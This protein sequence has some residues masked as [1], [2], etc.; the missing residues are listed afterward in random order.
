MP[1]QPH[2]GIGRM[3]TPRV[4]RPEQAGSP[5]VSLKRFARARTD[6]RRGLKVANEGVYRRPKGGGL[7]GDRVGDFV[8]AGG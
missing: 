5:G 3:L 1:V 8:Q 6:L 2:K 7:T 4:T